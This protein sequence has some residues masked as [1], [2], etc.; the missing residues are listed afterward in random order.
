MAWSD[1]EGAVDGDPEDPGPTRGVWQFLLSH[2]KVVYSQLR[3]R[4]TPSDKPSEPRTRPAY[5]TCCFYDL[6]AVKAGQD[7][8]CGIVK[9]KPWQR[10]LLAGDTRLPGQGGGRGWGWGWQRHRNG[11]WRA[12][13]GDGEARK[14]RRPG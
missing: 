3:P 13:A 9:G 12:G 7:G 5:R 4:L 6:L 11:A 2:E 1:P 8:G 10:L 14:S